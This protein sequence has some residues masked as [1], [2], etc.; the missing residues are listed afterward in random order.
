MSEIR[1]TDITPE[2]ITAAVFASAAA[3][4]DGID[5]DID[6]SDDDIDA[7]PHTN[8]GWTHDRTARQPTGDTDR[9]ERVVDLR[10]TASS[11]PCRWRGS[12]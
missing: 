6:D 4:D 2:A 1:G 9:Q 3:T 8:T 11:W 7:S 12:C 5:R 10:G